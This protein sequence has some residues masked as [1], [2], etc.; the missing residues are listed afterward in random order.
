MKRLLVLLILM[1]CGINISQATISVD[2]GTAL[3]TGNTYTFPG[4]TVTGGSGEKG[5]LVRIMFTRAVSGTDEIKLPALPPG[6]TRNTTSSTKYVQVLNPPVAGASITEL[7]SFLQGIQVV[8]DGAKKGHGIVVLI[9]ENSADAGRNIYYCSDTDNWYEHILDNQISWFNAYN[10]SAVKTFMGQS[11]YLV[12][13]TGK[14]ENDF[15]NTLISQYTWTSGTRLN[16]TGFQAA[17]NTLTSLPTTQLEYWYWAAGPEWENGG[18]NPANSVFFNRRTDGSAHQPVTVSYPYT[19]WNNGEPNDA[20][21]GGGEFCVHFY[22]PSGKWNDFNNNDTN[23]KGYI[24][25]YSG[26]TAGTSI[27]LGFGSFKN[28]SIGGVEDN[29]SAASPV[30]LNYGD[31]LT[32]TIT[33]ANISETSTSVIVRDTLP[34]GLSLVTGS[35]TNG[36][37]YNSTT[38]EIVW[39]LTIPT[40]DDINISFK[41][42]KRINFAGSIVNSAY[43]ICN[44]TSVRQTN[45]TYHM[46][47]LGV[48]E[49]PD[50]ISDADCFI[51]PP[52]MRWSIREVA[53]NWGDMFSIVQ[54]PIIGD[55]DGDG[56]VEIITVGS[57]AHHTGNTANRVYVIG[58]SSGIIK[59]KF[60]IPTG[61]AG[62]NLLSGIARIQWTPGVYRNVIF[63]LCNFPSNSNPTDGHHIF[64]YDP[65]IPGNNPPLWKSDVQFSSSNSNDGALMQIIDLD[66]DGWVELVVGNKVYAA[67][68]GK[69]LCNFGTQNSNIG[70]V[71]GWQFTTAL[72]TFFT[73]QS[74]AGEVFGNGKQQV[75]V[76]NSIYEVT[77]AGSRSVSNHAG[78][79]FVLAETIPINNAVWNGTSYETPPSTDG[80]TQLVDID[81]DGHLDVVVSTVKRDESNPTASSFYI[82]VWSHA[83]QKII[84]SRIVNNVFKRSVPFIGN[85]DKKDK[86]PEIVFIHGALNG[87]NHHSLDRITALKYKPNDPNGQLEIFWQLP[88][89]DISGA[90]GI[91]LFDFNQDGVSEL[92]YRDNRYLRIIN[93]SGSSHNPPFNDTIPV[94]NL[95]VY[96]CSSGTA[97]EYPVVADIDGDG[98]AE[99]ISGGLEVED[100]VDIGPMR[101]FKAD[102]GTYWAPARKVWNQFPYNAVYVNEDLTVPRY[103]LNPAIVFPGQDGVLGTADDERPFNNFLQQQTMLNKDGTPLWLTPDAKIDPVASSITFTGNSV[104]V[105]AC[106]TNEGDASI[107]S[108]IFVTLYGNTISTANILAMDSANIQ[109]AVD[110][111]GCITVTIP[112]I[113]QFSPMPASIIVRIND[114]NNQFAYQAECD[115]TNNE[116]PF[117]NQ[118][119]MEKDA[120]LL[121]SPPFPS[122]GTYPNPVSVLFNERIEYKITAVNASSAVASVVIIDTIPAYLRYVT[123][124]EGI[125]TT[126]GIPLF[127]SVTA[128][129]SVQWTFPGVPSM[130]VI[131]ARFEAEPTSGAVASQPLFIN[132]AWVKIGSMPQIATNSTFHQGAGISIMTFSASLGGTIYNAT[133]QALDYKTTPASGIL[134]VPDEGYHF[135]GWSHGDYVSL[136]GVEVK[137]QKG[138]MQYDTLTVYGNVELHANFEIE[139]YAISY[140]LN[141]SENAFTNPMSYTIKSSAIALEA[142]EKAGDTFVGWTGSNGEE[143][144]SSIVITNGSTGGLSFYANFLHSGREDVE[145]EASSDTDDMA[146]AVKDDLYMRTSKAGSVVRVYSLDG[147]LRDQRTIVAPG[148]TT[149]K[150][151]RGIYVVT[152]NNSTGKKVVLTE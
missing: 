76:G 95:A 104:T 40:E 142:P 84:A 131:T 23:V 138:I 116:M 54:T 4:L 135:A 123:G 83:K 68:T 125:T 139:E 80:A 5:F 77:L 102:F 118:L 30:A 120:T 41:A 28:A 111:S 60:N 147:V 106:F 82:Y 94:Y 10:A 11:G 20:S 47:I 103:P 98:Q 6:W 113:T 89:D 37:V 105:N 121:I 69:L 70:L 1:F 107:G 85:I 101:I 15:I 56:E 12:T 13:V 21:W 14:A 86:Y 53:N 9:S 88:H 100:H 115:S 74:V 45:R 146:W 46:G 91:T 22:S 34:G 143:P 3:K 97:Y 72:S 136:R 51:I 108:P 52:A 75:C 25:E 109:V 110:S 126:G 81:L 48:P 39:T 93:G 38:R 55:I 127:S 42:E 129:N 137:A 63:V 8:V 145:I 96:D 117:V 149:M 148:T 140:Y 31:V 130:G 58:A 33:A 66:G 44:G 78:N 141:G 16:I 152:I 18:K 43:V 79:T 19:N 49:Y 73:R 24:T 124:T 92:V 90:T 134:V 50:N 87:N 26:V 2:F 119:V 62:A 27:L 114:R 59:N 128:D 61:Y 67:E 36:G 132:K 65:L 64:A 57:D 150:L 133:E 151:P 32:Y 7:E 17:N 35:I 71:H 29:G 144:Q 99:I 112:D 122:R